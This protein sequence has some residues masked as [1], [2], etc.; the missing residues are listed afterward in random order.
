M[1]RS[2]WIGLLTLVVIILL[3]IST[4]L[5]QLLECLRIVTYDDSSSSSSLIATMA[6]LNDTMA[7]QASQPPFI[8]RTI[9]QTWKTK[10]LS[11]YSLKW[12]SRSFWVRRYPGWDVRLWTDAEIDLLIR[13]EYQWLYP[14]FISYPYD[15]ERADIARLVLLH[16]FGGVYVDLDVIPQTTGALPLDILRTFK[17]IFPQ[18]SDHRTLSNHFIMCEP[19]SPVLAELLHQASK[20]V[21]SLW[22]PYLHVFASTGPLFITHT[23]VQNSS[24]TLY[25]PGQAR[26]LN[27]FAPRIID[28]FIVHGPGRSWLEWDGQFFNF[29]ADRRGSFWIFSLFTVICV[30]G[31]CWLRKNSRKRQ[32][33]NALLCRI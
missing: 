22:L 8:P 26:S 6:E 16:K 21:S 13:Q 20:S 19:G 1:R 5:L 25:T 12:T 28:K 24:L 29:F 7:A 14:T 11:T 10:D 31:L 15:I 23:L 17:C 32:V 4:Q 27:F 33:A 2:W 3:F 30:F 9:H 18:A